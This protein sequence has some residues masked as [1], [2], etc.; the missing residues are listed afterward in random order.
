M[1]YEAQF[2]VTIHRSKN[3]M[4]RIKAGTP[5]ANL[6]PH[7]IRASLSSSWDEPI[8]LEVWE[9]PTGMWNEGIGPT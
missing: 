1:S 7:D 4:R 5:Y 6:K 8:F 9:P 3:L 2:G